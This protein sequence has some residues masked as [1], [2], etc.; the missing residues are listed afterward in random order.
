MKEACFLAG[1]CGHAWLLIDDILD[2]D[3]QRIQL[4]GYLSEV[5][6]LIAGTA[7]GHRFSL[8]LLNGQ[9]RGL[10]QAVEQFL[11]GGIRASLPSFAR[12]DLVRVGEPAPPQDISAPPGS[13]ASLSSSVDMLGEQ[14]S[15]EPEPWPLMRRELQ[16]LLTSSPKL[17][18]RVALM[19]ASGSDT[20]GPIQFVDDLTAA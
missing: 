9:L 15:K 17:A 6:K 7:Q 12:E 20:I 19:E 13:Y 2:A 5:F 3:A 10:S 16:L 8:H 4:H 18:D 14:A 11:N 1:V